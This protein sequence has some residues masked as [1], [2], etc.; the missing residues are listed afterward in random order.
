MFFEFQMCI[1]H[2]CTTVT[3]CPCAHDSSCYKRQLFLLAS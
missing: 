2:V 1:M 3:L